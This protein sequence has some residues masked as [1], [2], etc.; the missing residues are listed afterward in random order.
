MFKRNQ[1]LKLMRKNPKFFFKNH[2]E[3]FLKQK[4]SFIDKKNLKKIIF[5]NNWKKK[6]YFLK[7][8]GKKNL[9]TF[10]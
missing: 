6:T 5:I 1:Y 4:L 9:K 7:K 2:S 8:K 3:K 10:E